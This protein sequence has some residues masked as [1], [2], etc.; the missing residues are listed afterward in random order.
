[1]NPS[2]IWL[3]KRLFRGNAQVF[4]YYGTSERILYFCMFRTGLDVILEMTW[5]G[6]RPN[7]SIFNPEAIG[8]FILRAVI[9]ALEE[10]LEVEQ[11]TP[12]MSFQRRMG[13]RKWNVSTTRIDFVIGKLRFLNFAAISQM[14]AIFMQWRRKKHVYARKKWQSYKWSLVIMRSV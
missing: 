4:V 7:R 8:I 10:R 11:P 3:R 1:M 2:R 9:T 14:A 12:T 13:S 6:A 5:Q